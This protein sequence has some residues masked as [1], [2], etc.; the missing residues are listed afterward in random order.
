[1]PASSMALTSSHQVLEEIWNNSMPFVEM[2]QLSQQDSETDNYYYPVHN[3]T[4]ISH[5]RSEFF[6]ITF[7]QWY[8]TKNIYA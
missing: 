6:F 8:Q 1:M 3:Q 7:N 5:S 2:N 4:F